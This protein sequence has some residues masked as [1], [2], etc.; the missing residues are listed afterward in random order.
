MLIS[1]AANLVIAVVL[2]STN[3]YVSIIAPEGT[4]LVP[5]RACSHYFQLQENVIGS[6]KPY[7]GFA[8]IYLT[9]KAGVVKAH[10]DVF[11]VG[12]T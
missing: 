12:C 6:A 5:G 9:R 4:G 8:P 3:K 1:R 7:H 2:I 10:G 11:I